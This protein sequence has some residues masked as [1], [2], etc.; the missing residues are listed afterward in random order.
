[1]S[2]RVKIITSKLHI[3]SWLLCWM[4]ERHAGWCLHL[5]H[6][7][8][9]QGSYVPISNDA[10]SFILGGSHSVVYS[11]FCVTKLCDHF[12]VTSNSTNKF[13]SSVKLEIIHPLNNCV[14]QS[15]QFKFQIGVGM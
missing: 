12:V 15:C 9:V 6:I 13:E 4:S 2:I 10:F 11:S 14:S 8:Q 7:I 1:M 5:E 3:A